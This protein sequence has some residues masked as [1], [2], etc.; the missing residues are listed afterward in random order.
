VRW[1]HFEGFLDQDTAGAPVLN[2]WT[3]PPV[4]VVFPGKQAEGNPAA[5]IKSTNRELSHPQ[6]DQEVFTNE[7]EIVNFIE[8]LV[9]FTYSLNPLYALKTTV[10]VY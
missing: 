6:R 5:L 2:N 9:R 10:R 7:G 4:D 1:E 3:P 8:T